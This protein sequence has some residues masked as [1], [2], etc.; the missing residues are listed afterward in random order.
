MNKSSLALHLSLVTLNLGSSIY[1]YK[2]YFEQGL[3]FILTLSFSSSRGYLAPEYAL[4]GQLTMKADV[5]SFGVVVLEVISGRSSSSSYWGGAQKLLLEQVSGK[6]HLFFGF[7]FTCLFFL[8][9]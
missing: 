6:L 2:T 3:L 9:I 4:G 1:Q 5:Y 7:S 8:A